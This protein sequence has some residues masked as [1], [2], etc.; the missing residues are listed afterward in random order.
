[1]NG[2]KYILAYRF[3]VL[4]LKCYLIIFTLG[5]L[6]PKI[7]D[8]ILWKFIIE[9]NRYRDIT[10]V[11]NILSGYEIILYKYTYMINRFFKL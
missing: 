1:M 3:V 9:F 7:I 2:N 8:F 11:F 5:I 10:F 4:L 6:I